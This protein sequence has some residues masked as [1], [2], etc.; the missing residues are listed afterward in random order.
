MVAADSCFWSPPLVEG[1]SGGEQEEAV[2]GED[3]LWSAA[4][5]DGGEVWDSPFFS[6]EWE[7]RDSWLP[8]GVV[9][10]LLLNVS[11]GSRSRNGS[12]TSGDK[13]NNH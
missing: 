13:G 7:D 8:M 6:E 11:P 9:L 12:G 2:G 5:E 10:G 3:K 4:G 1:W